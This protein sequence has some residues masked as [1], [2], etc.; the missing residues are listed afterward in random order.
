[1][2]NTNRLNDSDDVHLE[3]HDRHDSRVSNPRSLSS[4]EDLSI[5]NNVMVLKNE[6]HP[7]RKAF[8]IS[9][10]IFAYKRHSQPGEESLQA[11]LQSHSQN[12]LET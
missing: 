8:P 9:G 4:N 3:I 12:L 11:S 6:K 1:L 10:K 5:V 2:N 7:V